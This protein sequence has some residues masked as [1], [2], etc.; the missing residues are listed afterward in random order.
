MRL[1]KGCLALTAMAAMLALMLLSSWIDGRSSSPVLAGAAAARPKNSLEALQSTAEKHRES[2]RKEL[3]LLAD[4]CR[5]KDQPEGLSAIESALAPSPHLAI[6]GATLPAE[7]RPPLPAGLSDDERYWRTQLQ[8]R[9]QELARQLYLVSR[10]A[11]SESSWH[12]SLAYDLIREA[13]FHDPDQPQARRL[14]GFI[15]E[16]QTW[17][18]PYAKDLLRRKFVWHE[19]F[20]WLPKNDLP[21]YLNGERRV[22]AQ[23]MSPEKEAEIRQDFRRAWV[24]RTDHYEVKTNV[25][26]ERGV[27]FGKALEAFHGFFHQTFASFFADP[28]QLRKLFADSGPITG[29]QVKPFRVHFYRS[30][31]E[32]VRRLQPQFPQIEITNGIYLTSDRTAHFYLDDQADNAAT[33][34][35]EATHQLFYESHPQERPIAEKGHFWLIEGIACYMESF[36]QEGGEFSVGDPRYIRFAGAR[37]NFLDQSYYVPLQQFSAWGMPEFQKSPMLVK[38][39]TQAA[40]MAQFFMQGRQGEYR[41]ALIQQLVQLYSV[42]PRKREFTTGLDEL[43][44]VSYDQLDRE[45][46]EFLEECAAEVNRAAGR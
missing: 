41:D 37:M 43:T 1:R 39:Y 27:E 28:E 11:V 13:A 46:G 29:R 44:G 5:R 9:Q 24:I 35:H 21:R 20:G 30:R 23:W 15:A 33:L 34:Y 14:L 31:D 42:D 32:Y 4:F 17:V 12:P 8:Y 7:K 22:D 25:S 16:G 19:Q 38:N 18:T 2:F 26:L 45:Y 3:G 10:R 6:H 40:G 36:R